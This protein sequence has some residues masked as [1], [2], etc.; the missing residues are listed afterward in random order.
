MTLHSLANTIF[1]RGILIQD[2]GGKCTWI[3]YMRN[4]YDCLLVHSVFDPQMGFTLIEYFQIKINYLSCST[5]FFSIVT[6][7]RTILL[8]RPF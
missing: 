8:E 1:S 6:V 3:V 4:Q 7:L 5:N 2:T